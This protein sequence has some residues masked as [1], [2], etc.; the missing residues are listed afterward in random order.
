MTSRELTQA[1]NEILEDGLY[2]NLVVARHPS[3]EYIAFENNGQ[4]IPDECEVWP[5]I[6]DAVES[7]IWGKVNKK[8]YN[9]KTTWKPYSKETMWG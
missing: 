2:V 9:E 7:Y 5:T 8:V 3:G 6:G 4:F 1:Q